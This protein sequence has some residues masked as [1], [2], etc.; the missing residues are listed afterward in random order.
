MAPDVGV[1]Y[2]SHMGLLICGLS[3][4]NLPCPWRVVVMDFCQSIVLV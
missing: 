3:F 1:T 4:R 2:V